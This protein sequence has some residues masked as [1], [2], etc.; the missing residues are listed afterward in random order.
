MRVSDFLLLR[1]SI[2]PLSLSSPLPNPAP[3]PDPSLRVLTHILAL[4]R[5]IAQVQL[6]QFK[7]GRAV[8]VIKVEH[9]RQGLLPRPTVPPH[10]N[11][12]AHSL[13]ERRDRRDAPALSATAGLRSRRRRKFLRVVRVC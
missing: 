2:P 1:G 5:F 9:A 4:L 13:Y 6:L 10:P 11:R 3:R 8:R 7:Q 12:H